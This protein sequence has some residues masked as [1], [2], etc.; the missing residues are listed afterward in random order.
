[1]NPEPKIILF[2][3]VCN[4]CNR[5]VQFVLKHDKKAI[6][7]FA[8]L[9][10]KAAQRLLENSDLSK[11]GMD[12]ILYI[13]G[14]QVIRKS[15]AVLYILRDLRGLWKLAFGFMILPAFIRDFI[16]D[17]VAK[18]RYRVFGKRDSCMIPTPE[19]KNRFLD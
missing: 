11:P 5:T 8:L 14:N 16:Y 12:S 6:F 9:Q 13:R 19:L 1:M 3:G 15:T 4:L 7:K 10:S 17:I 18:N 2:D